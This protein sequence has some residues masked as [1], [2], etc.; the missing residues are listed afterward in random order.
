M[1]TACTPAVLFMMIG[2]TEA[3]EARTGDRRKVM[4]C[5]ICGK[6]ERIVFKSGGYGRDQRD[7]EGNRIPE[8]KEDGT[9]KTLF[10][11]DLGAVNAHKR[12]E[13]PEEF[14]AAEEQKA[15]NK[16]AKE[17]RARLDASYTG[18]VWQAAGKAVAVLTLEYDE[19]WKSKAHQ[20]RKSSAYTLGFSNQ[21]VHGTEDYARLAVREGRGHLP[22]DS[23]HL[24]SVHQVTYIQDLELDT[25]DAEI[26]ALQDKRDLL[27]K[28]IYDASSALTYSQVVDVVDAREAAM[29][30]LNRMLDED[31]GD[32]GI[33][34]QPGG[35]LTN[36][37]IE[38]IV[39]AAMSNHPEVFI[40]SEPMPEEQLEDALSAYGYQDAA[41]GYI[42]GYC[43]TCVRIQMAK[44][45][46]GE[47]I[48]AF[49]SVSSDVCDRC[50]GEPESI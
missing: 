35:Q 43:A 7:A 17:Q 44:L 13:H 23:F 32:L 33:A 3:Q 50:F 20:N 46:G 12:L 26:E 24:R 28:D 48:P 11:H 47:F 19:Y 6:S 41:Q 21:Y 36:S 14:K 25:L 38:I 45:E 29:V 15:A 2:P 39:E 5:G 22:E 4:K 31:E 49:R 10:M 1:S 40:K 8:T 42:P 9:V 37:D 34:D 18:D 30:E 27:A 16:V